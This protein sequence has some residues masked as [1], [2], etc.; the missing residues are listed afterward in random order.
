MSQKSRETNIKCVCIFIDYSEFTSRF[1]SVPAAVGN[2][3]LGNAGTGD[4]TVTWSP[5]PGDVDHYEV[6]DLSFI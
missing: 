4:L 6:C 5:A 1:P 2:L 3:S